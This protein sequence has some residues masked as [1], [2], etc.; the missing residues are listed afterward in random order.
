MDTV[1]VWR[2]T[3]GT[4]VNMIA[5]TS[6]ETAIRSLEFSCNKLNEKPRRLDDSVDAVTRRS[7]EVWEAPSNWNGQ[8][9]WTKMSLSV[10]YVMST[11]C[12]I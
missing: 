10:M 5:F 3:D 9:I 7:V 8:T 11:V 1:Y 6:R 4:L 2:Y 12:H